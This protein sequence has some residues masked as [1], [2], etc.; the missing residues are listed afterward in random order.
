MVPYLNLLVYVSLTI[1]AGFLTSY[2]RLSSWFLQGLHSYLYP[3]NSLGKEQQDLQSG[4][5]LRNM[6]EKEVK[7]SVNGFNPSDN[8]SVD[9]EKDSWVEKE[10]RDGGMALD[11]LSKDD[12]PSESSSSN[13][14]SDASVASSNLSTKDKSPALPK[15][16]KKRKEKGKDRFNWEEGSSQILRLSLRHSHLQGRHYYQEY[17]E[18]V[19]FSVV[20]VTNL[21]ACGFIS[22]VSAAYSAN[23]KQKN[24]SLRSYDL[25]P[26]LM[27][28]FAIYKIARLLAQVG[29][30]RSTSRLSELTLSFSVG[31]IGFLLALYVLNFAP[32]SLIDFGFEKADLNASGLSSS[33]LDIKSKQQ[34]EF[35]SLSS[36]LVKI[37]LAAFAGWVSGILMGP[38]HR[39]M[40]SFWLGTD[41]LQWNM[42]VISWGPITHILLHLNVVLPLFAAILWIQPMG[43]LF[44]ASKASRQYSI[45]QNAETPLCR[46][47]FKP[48][49]QWQGLPEVNAVDEKSCQIQDQWHDKC[50]EHQEGTKENYIMEGLRQGCEEPDRM[51]LDQKVKGRLSHAKEGEEENLP[52]SFS[53]APS[54]NW[55]QDFGMSK[56]MFQ[57]VQ[58]WS[59]LLSGLL[60]LCLFR[61]NMQTYLN[62]A[63]L[64]WYESL[65]RSKITNLELTR[66]K[67]I[68]NSYFLCRAAIQ[69]LVPGMLVVL[70]LGMSRIYGNLS[71][72]NIT[73][74]FLSGSLFIR[75]SALFM[76]WWV[77]FTWA[78]LTCVILA[79]YRIGFL[80]AT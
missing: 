34:T 66:A 31:F 2:L 47:A 43:E 74:T 50:I 35:N 53:P 63:V 39:S 37:V 58:F 3:E 8:P 20:G 59:L 10:G 41:Q 51:S 69:F 33:N 7:S 70:F 16:F 30:E 71:V 13:K 14:E 78:M 73:G 45:T 60:Q 76:A 77:T 12:K 62:E 15:S 42:P 25:I 9:T 18:A 56:K 72:S 5:G 75:V 57:E 55:A 26:F 79:L 64:I 48:A 21:L 24:Q 49:I 40:R 36:S 4:N 23:A 32:T 1:A 6:K 44:I 38:A 29:W 27:G 61:V 22:Y 52:Y 54:G 28:L 80:L 67:L 11:E 68:L 46:K 19:I 65:H 17:D